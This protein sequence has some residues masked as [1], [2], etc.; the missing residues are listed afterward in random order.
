MYSDF[1]SQPAVINKQMKYIFIQAD[2]LWR[3]SLWRED[4]VNK[5]IL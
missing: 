1:T 2:K 4:Y 5:D 3:L